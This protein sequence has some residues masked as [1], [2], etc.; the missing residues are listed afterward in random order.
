MIHGF[1]VISQFP[2]IDTSKSVPK[3]LFFF[4]I[5]FIAHLREVRLSLLFSR[6]FS[7]GTCARALCTSTMRPCSPQPPSPPKAATALSSQPLDSVLIRNRQ[8]LHHDSFRAHNKALRFVPKHSSYPPVATVLPCQP[9][10]D[11]FE[12][13]M[14]SKSQLT[15]D[16]VAPHR[17]QPMHFETLLSFQNPVKRA[18]HPAELASPLLH[19]GLSFTPILYCMFFAGVEFSRLPQSFPAS[20]CACLPDSSAS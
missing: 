17:P 7:R 16:S 9:T 10:R 4:A 3:V 12:N 6:F 13:C 1:T 14:I 15:H 19:F 20:P 11:H 8:P 5:E 2:K 18:A